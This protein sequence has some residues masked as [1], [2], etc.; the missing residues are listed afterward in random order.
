MPG[1]RHSSVSSHDKYKC[2]FK[3]KPDLHSQMKEP[4]VLRQY[5]LMG[6]TFPNAHSSIS[7]HVFLV[8]SNL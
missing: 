4:G 3:V 8:S 7:S 5:E 1:V 6:H 2:D